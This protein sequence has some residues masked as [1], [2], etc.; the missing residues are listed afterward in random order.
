MTWTN[1]FNVE[2]RLLDMQHK[3]LFG[4]MERLRVG[5]LGNSKSNTINEIV[6]ALTQYTEAHF[7]SEERL[8]LQSGYLDYERHKLVHDSMV[9]KVQRYQTMLVNGDSRIT[10]ELHTYLVSWWTNHILGT[11]KKYCSHFA[12]NG[13]R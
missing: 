4:L 3:K 7:L 12:T 1:E 10:E 8:M 5:A 11:D 9:S 13:I 6:L 2:V